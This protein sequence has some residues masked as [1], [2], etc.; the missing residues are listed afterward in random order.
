MPN[1]PKTPNRAMRVPED[2]WAHA[3]RVSA[4]RGETVTAVVVAALQRYVDRYGRGTK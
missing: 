3:K 4:E 2:L 1:Q